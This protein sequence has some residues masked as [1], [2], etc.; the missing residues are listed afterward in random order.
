MAFVLGISGE[1]GSGK[2]T[3]ANFIQQYIY[4]NTNSSVKIVRFADPLKEGLST[5]LN[6]D[7]HYFQ[8]PDLK[9]TKIDFYDVSPRY[10][11]T[12]LGTDWGRKMVRNDIWLLA[13][14]KRIQDS[15]ADVILVPDVRFNNEASEIIR[16]G[17]KIISVQKPVY[18]PI[19]S[20][21]SEQGIDPSFFSETVQNDGSLE[22]LQCSVVKVFK[23]LFPQLKND[24]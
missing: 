20:H 19:I 24:F 21:E 9:N 14:R 12:S 16:M 23:N 2:D 4:E 17:G 1:A 18:N 22:K 11:M 10:L 15:E 6:V 7:I 8:D 5:M 3:A 13:F